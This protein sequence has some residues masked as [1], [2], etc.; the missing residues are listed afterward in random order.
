MSGYARYLQEIEE[1]IA[2]VLNGA[3]S[4]AEQRGHEGEALYRYAYTLLKGAI[5]QEKK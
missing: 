4:I 2:M 1:D 5:E 3:M